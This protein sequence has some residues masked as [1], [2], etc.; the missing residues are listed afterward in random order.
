MQ[1]A[2]ITFIVQILSDSLS[3]FLTCIFWW[4][5]PALH[6]CL[7]GFSP[8][9]QWQRHDGVSQWREEISLHIQSSQHG[10]WGDVDIISTWMNFWSHYDYLLISSMMLNQQQWRPSLKIEIQPWYPGTKIKQ[11][12]E[13]CVKLQCD[14]E[15]THFYTAYTECFNWMNWEI[16][17]NTK[18]FFLYDREVHWSARE[19][20]IIRLR[21]PSVDA[22]IWEIKNKRD[23]NSSALTAEYNN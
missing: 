14:V 4:L 9:L 7:V 23:C 17:S 13:D 8:F 2:F 5:G 12:E 22:T 18:D 16:C 21:M 6:L 3:V 19:H 20:M 1:N 15:I 11:E 10:W